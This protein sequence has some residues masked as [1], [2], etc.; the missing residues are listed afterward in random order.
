VSVAFRTTL[1][2]HEQLILVQAQQSAACNITH[3]VE[4]RLARWLLRCRDLMGSDNLAL[5]QGVCWSNARGAASERVDHG[6]RI[7]AGW[8]DP[9]QPWPYS[10]C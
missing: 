1:I 5:T 4:A 9:I 10:H 6:G 7:A 3:S 2:R 8:F